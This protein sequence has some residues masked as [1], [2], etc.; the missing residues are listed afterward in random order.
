VTGPEHYLEAERLTRIGKSQVVA[1]MQMSE[2]ERAR[3]NLMAAAN[4]ASLAA[5]AAT[6]STAPGQFLD[7]AEW[8]DAITS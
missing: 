5:V 3:L 4:H 6:I 1:G 7:D 8:I 2:L